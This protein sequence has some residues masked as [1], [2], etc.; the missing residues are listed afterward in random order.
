MKSIKNELQNIIFGN[1][2]VGATSQLK[3]VQSFLRA[4]EKASFGSEKQKY[5]K[6]K[7]ASALKT[8]C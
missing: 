2:S 5:L 1:G 7:E 8:I 3:K 4:N 6:G